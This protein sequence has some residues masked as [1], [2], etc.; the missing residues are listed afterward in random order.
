M[1]MNRVFGVL[2]ALLSVALIGFVVGCGSDDDDSTS[3]AAS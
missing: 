2:A 3:T 1:R